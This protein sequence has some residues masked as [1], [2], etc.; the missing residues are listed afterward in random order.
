[1]DLLQAVIAS[2]RQG[3]SRCCRA[4]VTL[5]QSSSSANPSSPAP[6][7]VSNQ[8]PRVHGVLRQSQ[9]KIKLVT[10]F[11]QVVHKPLLKLYCPT[12]ILG[13]SSSSS[14]SSSSRFTSTAS[15]SDSW[16]F[17]HSSMMVVT[18]DQ[19]HNPSFA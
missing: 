3:Q 12:L 17:S 5:F 14:S 15:T 7:R 13:P 9:D 11:C 2:K 18:P 4:N 8:A 1:M 6:Y 16:S 10:V 19:N